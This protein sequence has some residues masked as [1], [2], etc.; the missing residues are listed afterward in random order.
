MNN[1]FIAGITAFAAV[2]LGINIPH[3]MAYEQ[4]AEVDNL[5]AYLVNSWGATNT[6]PQYAFDGDDETEWISRR[7]TAIPYT[8]GAVLD[9]GADNH[10]VVDKI[11]IVSSENANKVA[12]YGTDNDKIANDIGAVGNRADLSKTENMRSE[13]GLAP[14]ALGTAEQINSAA[15]S[16]DYRFI[17]VV[18]DTSTWNPTKEIKISEV[19][20]FGEI[21]N[22]SDYTITENK[23]NCDFDN[24]ISSY[25]G[26]TV[27]IS[28]CDLYGDCCLYWA[29]E[30]GI[31][32]NTKPLSEMFVSKYRNNELKLHEK[33]FIPEG[34]VYLKAY[35]DNNEVLSYTLPEEKRF[36]EKQYGEKLYSFGQLSDVHQI[37]YPDKFP[38]ALD[39]FELY[40]CEM[41]NICGDITQENT[42]EELKLYKE[43]ADKYSMPIYVSSGNHDVSGGLRAD[44]ETYTGCPMYYTVEHGDDVFLYMGMNE[45]KSGMTKPFTDKEMLWLEGE[46]KKYKDK[47]VF[48][49]EHL[50]LDNTVGNLANM[51]T[52]ETLYPASNIM[53]TTGTQDIKL[54]SLLK[55]YKNVIHFSGHS[56]WKYYLQKFNSDLNIFDGG[57]EY[58]TMVHVSSCTVP[59]ESD[60]TTR[61]TDSTASEG[62]V[63]DV[64]KDY[65]VFKAMDFIN[66]ENIS[67]ATYVVET[68]SK[69]NSADD[70]SD[71][72]KDNVLK[73]LGSNGITAYR[74]D[75]FNAEALIDE[76]I[77]TKGAEVTRQ[78]KYKGNPYVN[79]IIIDAGEGNKIHA[80]AME[81][82]GENIEYALFG[83]DEAFDI[84]AMD[85]AGKDLTKNN[86]EEFKKMFPSAVAI[87][88]KTTETSINLD[89]GNGFRYMLIAFTT[90]TGTIGV[91]DIVVSGE[92]KSNVT[93]ELEP[94][95]V[96]TSLDVSG[97]TLNFTVDT[98]EDVLGMNVYT[99]LYDENGELKGV[100]CNA[101]E[102]EFEI[103]PQKRYVLKAYVWNKNTMKPVRAIY[104]ERAVNAEK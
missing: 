68:T 96:I 47:R 20:L 1:R 88:E 18:P 12:I 30:N 82:T 60:G 16:C 84:G 56:H 17:V 23:L 26:G 35:I 103:E 34:A 104:D 43:T 74:M 51:T 7:A 101:A 92:I 2:C 72:N 45:W 95:A 80:S 4:K 89:N 36:S 48:L 21:C 73:K 40:G 27:T 37:N 87:R 3:A 61:V 79:A 15:I 91:S 49:Q 100:K 86:F 46:L 11:F 81:L 77:D 14:I 65:V 9:A 69:K 24:D 76:D 22:V 53:Q 71:E 70:E 10:F 83:S 62:Y 66:D 5:S 58:C 64:Y 19:T 85:N 90:W 67:E 29:D 94:I 75:S 55:K 13:Y 93:A 54:R 59:I 28:S 6:N 78:G 50:F 39:Y 44:W 57:G 42:E 38:H 32:D 52:G 33:L 25:G 31:L 41:V 98:E 8:A 63:V 97:N 102:G 99:A